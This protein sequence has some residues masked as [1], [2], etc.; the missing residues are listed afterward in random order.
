MG[1]ARLLSDMP[2]SELCV[3]GLLLP[4]AVSLEFTLERFVAESSPLVFCSAEY[5]LPMP[6]VFVADESSMLDLQPLLCSE[7]E[8]KSQLSSEFDSES[9]RGL[10]R[11][12]LSL[13]ASDCE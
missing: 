1:N 8:S 12:C 11:R 2:P 5:R 10:D 4:E 13:T 6:D 3:A 7:A 9:G